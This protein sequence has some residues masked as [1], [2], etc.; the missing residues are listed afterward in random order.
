MAGIFLWVGIGL[1][2]YAPGQAFFDGVRLSGVW[3]DLSV[4]QLVGEIWKSS[5]ALAL[6]LAIV[7]IA[8]NSIGAQNKE[9]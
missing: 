5:G 4:W 6:G 8:S 2:A 1:I 7:I 3:R 9:P